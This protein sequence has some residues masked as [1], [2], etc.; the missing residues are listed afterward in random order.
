MSALHRPRTRVVALALAVVLAAE[1][2]GIAIGARGASAVEP[3]AASVTTASVPGRNAPAEAAARTIPSDGSAARTLALA[4]DA[5]A[6][7]VAPRERVSVSRAAAVRPAVAS[8]VRSTVLEKPSVPVYRGRNHVWIPALGINRSVS[9][10]PCSRSR[11]P[12]DYVYRWGCAGRNNVYLMGHAHSV[13]K[14]LHDAFVS[15]RLRKGLKVYYADSTGRVRTYAV[16]WWKTTRPTTSA[17]W[18]WAAQSRPSM[19]LQTCVG[20]KSAF[21]LMV[22]LV[23]VD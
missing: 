1:L 14:P 7:A 23:A 12:D 20:A 6:A 18:A 5:V 21:R 9:P 19:T 22:R 11:A 2:G 4:A 3:P 17:S 15:G 10:F 13:F 16:S 8:A